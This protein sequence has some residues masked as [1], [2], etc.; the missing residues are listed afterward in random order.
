LGLVL[1]CYLPEAGAVKVERDPAAP[2]TPQTP[3]APQATALP[4]PDLPKL[5]VAQIV[6]KNVAARGGLTA[7]RAVQTMQLSGKMDAGGK[8]DTLLPYTLQIKRPNKQRLAIEFAG[9]TSLQVYD[10]KSGWKLRPYLNRPDPEPFSAEEL[11]KTEQGP[12]FDGPLI[13][14]DAKGSKVELEGTEMVEDKA[15][16]RL[17][18]TNKQG[19]AHHIWIDGTTFLEAKVEDAPRRFGGKLRPVETYLGD[20]RT[21][22]GGRVVL[23]YLAETR[24]QGA[25]FNHK[26]TVEKVALNPKLD[27][28]LFGKPAPAS[29]PA[30][31]VFTTVAPTVSAATPATKASAAPAASPAQSK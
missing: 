26:M 3:K 14:Y 7:W 24:V 31:K 28:S 5:T 21:V 16:Y 1:A 12:G 11:R 23:P 20:Y 9:Q 15:T 13:D 22:E 30:A 29:L 17:K 18:L 4:A 8:V 10:G 6:E 25:H 19:N 27:D 2:A